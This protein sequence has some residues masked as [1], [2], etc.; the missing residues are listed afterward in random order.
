MILIN[1]KRKYLS[2]FII[3][4]IFLHC[5][6]STE[7]DTSQRID[8]KMS[9]NGIS[10]RYVLSIPKSYNETHASTPLILALH[11]GG[12]PTS[13]YGKDFLDILVEPAFKSLPV[14]IVSPTIPGAGNWTSADNENTVMALVDSLTKQYNIDKDRILITG[15]S[16]GAMGTWYYAA[17]HR[18]YFSAAIPVAGLPDKY[19][20]SS[21]SNIPIYVIHSRIDEVFSFEEMEQIV[22]DLKAKGREI[23]FNVVDYLSHYN[24]EGFVTPLSQSIPWIKKI[25]EQ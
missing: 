12:Q 11:F 2:F 3:G 9:L 18:D 4:L 22:N 17:K 8:S 6:N 15:F 1:L 13:T 24:T 19:I 10:I 14:F 21:A 5:K 25:W 23:E 7:M 16:M 20:A